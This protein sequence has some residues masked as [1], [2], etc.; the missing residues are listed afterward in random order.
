MTPR[1]LGLGVCPSFRSCGPGTPFLAFFA[2]SGAFA[3]TLPPP[4][5]AASSLPPPSRSLIRADPGSVAR[6]HV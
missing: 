1:F 6:G 5:S 2:R 3:G 4:G